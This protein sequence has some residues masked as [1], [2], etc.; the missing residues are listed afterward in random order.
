[1]KIA[2]LTRALPA[3]TGGGK[4]AVLLANT[5]VY[6]G[7]KVA[8]Y[9]V[10]GG[11]TQHLKCPSFII[12]EVKDD[13]DLVLCLDAGIMGEVLRKFME[14]KR[15]MKIWWVLLLHDNYKEIFENPSILKLCCCSHLT[16]YKG[17]RVGFVLIK[18]PLDTANYYPMPL[19]TRTELVLFHY[20]KS[21]YV[22]ILVADIIQSKRP[23]IK[24]ASLGL[25]I[26]VFDLQ[27]KYSILN[28]ADHEVYGDHAYLR[29]IYNKAK[30][31]FSTY[32]AYNWGGDLCLSE[33]AMCKCPVV[34]S[35][36][37]AECF[38][39]ILIE[40]VTGLTVKTTVLPEQYKDYKAEKGEGW[41]TRPDPVEVSDKVIELFDN[42]ELAGKLA[43]QAYEM[44]QE[45]SPENWYKEFKRLI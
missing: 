6:Y 30:V 4:Q 39:D 41:I 21:G 12:G 5:L 1:V 13:N 25:G 36:S 18:G 11:M 23:D 7:H 26:N 29:H 31:Y 38:S 24:V 28:F 10:E 34:A 45:M 27:P 17:N 35:P 37:D 43:E 9:S 33:A 15:G 20:K 44:A 42:R 40:G 22:G 14:L 2:I 19:M 32:S 3:G 8:V 16:Q